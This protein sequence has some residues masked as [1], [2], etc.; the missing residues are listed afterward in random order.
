MGGEAS[1]NHHARTAAACVA[2]A[3]LLGLVVGGAVA[4]DRSGVFQIEPDEV[5]VEPGETVEVDVTLITD[6]GYAGEGLSAYEYVVAYDPAVVTVTD[7]EHGPWLEHPEDAVETIAEFRDGEVFIRH[8]RHNAS[9]GETGYGVTATLTIEVHEDAPPSDVV[10]AVVEANGIY[11]S[12]APMATFVINGTLIV[13][14]GG[15]EIRPDVGGDGRPD[16]GDDGGGV[17][18]TTP[19][20]DRPVGESGAGSPADEPDGIP[21][22]GPG[23]GPL[24]G[25]IG[26]TLAG[27]VLARYR[28][29][30]RL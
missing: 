28:A 6:G 9:T 14:G 23:F 18:I 1:A 26:V 19:G 21:V 30:R 8:E 27:Y 29:G 3:V 7:V 22:V 17:G 16:V 5:G 2:V 25:L 10:L 4:G 15:E 12:E 13:D 24:A 20:E 11:T